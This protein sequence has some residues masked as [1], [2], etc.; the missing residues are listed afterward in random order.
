MNVQ[1]KLIET[2]TNN[3]I[4]FGRFDRVIAIAE[5]Y[6]DIHPSETVWTEERMNLSVRSTPA[7]QLEVNNIQ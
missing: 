1:D 7:L 5:K 2:L 6:S 3:S 4:N